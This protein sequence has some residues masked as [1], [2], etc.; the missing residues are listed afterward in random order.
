[1]IHHTPPQALTGFNRIH[2]RS[3]AGSCADVAKTAEFGIR[4]EVKTGFGAIS[5]GEI[6]W[7]IVTHDLRGR[8][9][10]VVRRLGIGSA[11]TQNA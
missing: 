10:R 2:G 4:R 8:D 6:I 1:M 7:R 5:E 11:Q 3:H 9:G